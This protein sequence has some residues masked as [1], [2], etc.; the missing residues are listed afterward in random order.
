MFLPF[1]R[2]RRRLARSDLGGFAGG[3]IASLSIAAGYVPIAISFGLVAV[4]AG[5]SPLNAVLVSALI[6]AGASQFVLVSLLTSGA[7]FFAALATLLL[8]NARHIFYGPA[9]SRKLPRTRSRLPR[10]LLALG[11]TDEVFAMSLARLDQVQEHRREAWH[12][13]L[14]IGAYKIGRAHV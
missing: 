13:G 1:A 7:G 12:L 2:V 10:A 3:L 5:L 8:M 6:F 9:L 4:Q 11:L 14:Q